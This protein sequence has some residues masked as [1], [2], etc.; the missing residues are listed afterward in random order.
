MDKAYQQGSQLNYIVLLYPIECHGAYAKNDYH[1]STHYASNKV[2][3]PITK[4]G[5]STTTALYSYGIYATSH[6]CSASGFMDSRKVS[7]F[8]S[9]NLLLLFG[10]GVAT[11]R[12]VIGT[13]MHGSTLTIHGRGSRFGRT[14]STGTIQGSR[15]HAQ[16]T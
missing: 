8:A 1:G 15:S 16:G 6:I 3:Y 10:L 12:A 4:N 9:K 14:K 13:I 2:T 11:N 7:G 5:Y